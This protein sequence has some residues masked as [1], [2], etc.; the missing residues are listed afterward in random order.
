MARRLRI[1]SS[2]NSPDMQPNISR[3]MWRRRPRESGNSL[4]ELAL[5]VTFLMLVVLG[6]VDFARLFYAAIE[7]NDAARAGAQYGS[8][9]VVTAA[10]ST[11]MV[12]AA[13]AN[14]TNLTGV[15]AS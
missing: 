7:V 13:K 6:T 4:I 3:R 12:N 9:S 10:D 1:R 15:T 14:A 11:G 5:T 2:M 8:Q